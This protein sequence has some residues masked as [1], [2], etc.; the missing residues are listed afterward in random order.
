MLKGMT[1][2]IASRFGPTYQGGLGAYTRL[3]IEGVQ[4]RT[5]SALTV[6]CA[7]AE[8]GSLPNAQQYKA[9]PLMELEPS[10]FGRISRPLWA[11]CA[12]KPLLHGVLE[13]ILHRAWRRP[14]IAP[15][16][17]IH[18]VGTGWDF[19]G[20]AMAKVARDFRARFVITPAL[21]PGAWGNDR[22]DGRLYRQAD[23]VIC[24]TGHEGSV[25]EQ[26]GVANTK[27]SVCALPPTCRSDGNGSR[28]REDRNLGVRPC[29]L[30]VGRRDEGKGYPALLQAWSLVLQAIPDAVLILAGAAGDQYRDL[31]GKIPERN[32]CDLGVPDEATKANAIAACDV[33]CLPSAHESFGIV[34]VDAWSYGKP[35]ICGTAP[36]CREFIID[37]ENGFW[38]NQIPEELAEKLIVL[39]QNQDLRR[40]LGT[41]GKLV[42]AQKYNH[43][44]FC[45]I[46]FEA[47][48]LNS[49]VR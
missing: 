16:D 6:I 43:D 4:D 46:H 40:A 33:F 1:T 47:F 2:W 37:G 45:Q 44:T 41:A 49:Q 48:G 23:R 39:L 28:L 18:Y 35:V 7:T 14:K 36:A 31:V 19:F 17:V 22:I 8:M 32:L 21:H 13:S 10:W 25:L 34:F 30:F 20:F 24:F 29:V 27:I 9:F 12:S 11:R 5:N 26:L 3:V 42:Q 38:A 15:P